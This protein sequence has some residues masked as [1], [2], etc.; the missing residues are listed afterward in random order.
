MSIEQAADKDA[1]FRGSQNNEK[2]DF[3]KV[4]KTSRM[5]NE[6]RFVLFFFKYAFILFIWCLFFDSFCMDISALIK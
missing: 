5:L 1:K 6:G 3:K 2:R 4:L